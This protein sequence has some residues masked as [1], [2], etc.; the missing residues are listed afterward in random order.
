MAEREQNNHPHFIFQ[1]SA[2][3]EPFK[4]PPIVVGSSQI[5]AKDR[6]AH[7][8]GLLSLVCGYCGL[9]NGG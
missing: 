8:G 7:G 3:A 4:S 5:P 2:Q 9:I 1:N 6:N